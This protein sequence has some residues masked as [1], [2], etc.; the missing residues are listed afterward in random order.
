[1]TWPAAPS[2]TPLVASHFDGPLD[3]PADARSQL[4]AMKTQVDDLSAKLAAIIGHGE[5][6]LKTSGSLAASPAYNGADDLVPDLG[7]VRKGFTP[8]PTTMVS[9]TAPSSVTTLDASTVSC[10]VYS[11]ANNVDLGL[12]LSG[13]AHGQRIRVGFFQ[14]GGGANVTLSGGT[15]SLKFSGAI[16]RS[17]GVLSWLD[18]VYNAPLNQ[19]EGV[20]T[21]AQ[22]RRDAAFNPS[23]PE[24]IGNTSA[25]VATYSIKGM[26]YS[27]GVGLLHFSLSLAW[28][29]HTGTGPMVLSSFPER[30]ASSSADGDWILVPARCT[31]GVTRHDGVSLA[32]KGSPDNARLIDANGSDLAITA[33][34]QLICSGCIP[35]V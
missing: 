8:L 19:W 25:G 9:V 11:L 3:V 5:P 30:A 21:Q 15:S 26:R 7:W 31:L 23:L 10:R 16:A 33:A 20:I 34:G 6:V 22:P 13:A 24:I 12:T 17:K 32:W 2:T 14:S 18:A 27:Y 29:G 1:M 4:L 28:T 35:F